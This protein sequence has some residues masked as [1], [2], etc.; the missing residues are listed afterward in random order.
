[1]KKIKIGNQT[2]D[3]IYQLH[4]QL[5]MG[6]SVTNMTTDEMCI[7]LSIKLTSSLDKT[8]NYDISRELIGKIKMQEISNK[9]V[10]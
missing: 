9:G 4:Y 1:M 7:F 10:T 2:W 6:K 8:L 5:S 3:K